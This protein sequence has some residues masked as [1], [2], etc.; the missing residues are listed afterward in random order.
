MAQTQEQ[1]H[2]IARA[3]KNTWGYSVSQVDGFFES[4][5]HL[6][7]ESEPNM[8]QAEIQNRAFD[9]EKNGYDIRAVDDALRRLEN[10]V[11]DKLAAWTIAHEGLDEW[12][13]QT[14]QLALTLI[15][16]AKRDKGKVFSRGRMFNPS[17]DVKQVD[18]FVIAIAQY[19]NE[20][21]SLGVLNMPED[22]NAKNSSQFTSTDVAR[23]IFTQRSGR[24]GY[25]E[26]QVD[27]YM[28]RVIEVLTHIE[29]TERMKNVDDQF[30]P[31]VAV[32]PTASYVEPL[33]P[34]YFNPRDSHRADTGADGFNNSMTA[35]D[36]ADEVS[37]S[38][39]DEVNSVLSKLR[40]ASSAPLNTASE[41]SG[42]EPSESETGFDTISHD[43][44][45]MF[46]AQSSSAASDSMPSSFAPSVKPE[47]GSTAAD[48]IL[49]Y[50]SLMDTGSIQSVQFHMPKLDDAPIKN[51]NADSAGE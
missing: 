33:I 18:A 27:A 14:E 48:D 30:D 51:D 46:D 38:A 10:A 22:H 43:E 47:R 36:G 3:K 16:R 2:G 21:L 4:T 41:Q 8:T 20:K 1:S 50:S 23:T 26:G 37:E 24:A 49:D 17:Y 31:V 32:D 28:N 5:R 9:L 35:Q 12:R 25:S 34:D 13:A 7:E 39:R 19:L 29:S 40:T 6:Y 11:V 44:E 45:K 15:P 42:S